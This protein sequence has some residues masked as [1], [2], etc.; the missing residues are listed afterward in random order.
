MKHLFA[1]TAVA[2]LATLSLAACGGDSD[3]SPE[4]LTEALVEQGLDQPT[5]ECISN[6]LSSQLSTD[7]FNDVALAQ[8]ADDIPAE[9]QDVLF[10]VTQDCILGDDG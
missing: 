6:E 8:T 9:L 4:T 2:S 3:V 7:D 1:V 5:A 10:Q